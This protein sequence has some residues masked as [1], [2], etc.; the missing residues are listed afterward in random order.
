MNFFVSFDSICGESA[1]NVGVFDNSDLIKSEYM[2]MKEILEQGEG[3]YVSPLSE[4][5]EIKLGEFFS[6]KGE[7]RVLIKVVPDYKYQIDLGPD[8]IYQTDEEKDFLLINLS[9]IEEEEIEFV[10]IV[11]NRFICES[12]THNWFLQM[13]RAKIE[14]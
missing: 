1:T 11:R 4:I 6:W 9:S 13:E 8:E 7:Q 5:K 10:Y 12:E 3:D 14:F 2:M